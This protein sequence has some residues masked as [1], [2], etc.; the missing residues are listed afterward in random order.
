MLQDGRPQSVNDARGIAAGFLCL[1]LALAL[2]RQAALPAAWAFALALVA[3]AVPIAV[4]DLI[5]ARVHLRPSTGLDWSLFR[6][7]PIDVRR[8]GIKILGMVLTFSTL[9]AL[10]AALPAE[11]FGL[12]RL[13]AGTVLLMLPLL[14]V[15]G[16]IYIV[17]LDR[18][19][20]EPRDGFFEA[21]SLALLRFRSRDWMLI[22]DFTLGWLIK[23]FFLPQMF[24]FLAG[25]IWRFVTSPVE[26]SLIGLVVWLTAVAVMLE[27]VVVVVGYTLTLRP[28]DTHIRS[29]N[30]YLSAWLACL[31]CY[32]PFNALTLH[33]AF[34]YNDGMN[35]HDWFGGNGWLAA[36]WGL[37]LVATYG[38]W[39]WATAIFGLRWS[40]LTNRGIITNGPYRFTK[41]PDYIAKS[42][43]WWLASVPFLSADGWQAAVLHSLMLAGVNAVYVLRAKTE[44]RH[45]MQDP[46]YRAYA[47]WIARHGVLAR[48]VRAMPWKRGFFAGRPSLP[49][50]LGP[51]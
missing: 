32:A 28:L 3:Y 46:A 20:V 10:Y 15:L 35:W 18:V 5:V 44:E 17:L 21:G 36:P 50:R 14:L 9:G 8:V 48:L 24:G 49:A 12:Y 41:H 39:V 2:A 40:N 22:R 37:L 23:G 6:T 27:L 43:F 38:L 7:Q 26:I 42:A 31:V 4:Y 19:M 1:I 11:V 16:V 45:L 25:Y 51:G 33:V 13:F 47:G 30:P 34:P 29:P